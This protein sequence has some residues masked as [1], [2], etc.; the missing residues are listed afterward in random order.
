MTNQGARTLGILK[1]GEVLFDPYPT[2][3][4]IIYGATG[5]A[6]TTS[7]VVPAI[8]SLLPDKSLALIINDVKDG[9]I[10]AQIADMCTKHGRNFG[11]L[12]D[13][14]VLGA[15]YPHRYSLN[16][17]GSIVSTNERN[18]SDLLYSIETAVQAIIP[19]P[20]GDSKNQYFRDVPRE[21][22]DLGIRILLGHRAW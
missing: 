7:V 16:A 12:D 13:F 15:D 8:Q 3:S 19:E 22:M 5:A 4:S 10:A 1:T 6:K 14:H 20:Q 11:V 9:E 17:F 18:E 2:T 21:E